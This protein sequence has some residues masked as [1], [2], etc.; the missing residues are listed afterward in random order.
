MLDGGKI[1]GSTQSLVYV[2]SGRFTTNGDK[3][4]GTTA[5]IR[6]ARMLIRKKD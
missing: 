1:S 3:I 5:Q 2:E 6:E 4:T